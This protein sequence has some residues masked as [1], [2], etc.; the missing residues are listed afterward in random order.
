MLSGD[1]CRCQLAIALSFGRKQGESSNQRSNKRQQEENQ[2]STV[3]IREETV[4]TNANFLLSSSTQ[5]Y[6]GNTDVLAIKLNKLKEKSARHTLHK[7]FLSQCINNKLVP[8]GLELTLEPTI[9]NFDQRFID[10]WCSELKDISLNLIED[11]VSLF[12]KIIKQTSKLTKP[13]LYSNNSCKEMD[14]SRYK[15]QS[16]Q[17]KH[18]LKEHYINEN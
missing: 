6:H 15:K 16:K 10:N 5:T 11:I 17:M 18:Q 8:K 9:R 12:N 2:V 7:D 14:T 3:T 13:K 1:A 4:I